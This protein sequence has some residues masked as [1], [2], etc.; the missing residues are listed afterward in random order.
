M[1]VCFGYEQHEHWTWKKISS[2]YCIVLHNAPV[3]RRTI[4]NPH[5]VN[6][7]THIFVGCLLLF[8]YLFMMRRNANDKTI[9]IFSIIIVVIVIKIP[10][11]AMSFCIRTS[12]RWSTNWTG[13]LSV[14]L[15]ESLRPSVA[16]RLEIFNSLDFLCRGEEKKKKL[17]FQWESRL[18]QS[19]MQ[20][21]T[22]FSHDWHEMFGLFLFR[23]RLKLN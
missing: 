8:Y 9:G 15:I 1:S 17:L 6:I 20:S 10:D 14:H 23:C 4:V 11:S 16:M 5:V 3:R 13:N 22:T 18:P 19:S 2:R 12:Y 21:R 7:Q